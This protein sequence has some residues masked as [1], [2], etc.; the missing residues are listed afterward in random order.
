[1]KQMK[2]WQDPANALIGAWLVASPWVLGFQGNS[3]A[4]SSS[5]VIGVALIAAAAGAMWLPQ[6]WEEWTEAAL[7]VLMMASP[8]L[9][10]FTGL[11]AARTSA[12]LSGLAVLALALWVLGTDKD[13]GFL[14]E[15]R[16]AH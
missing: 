5:L 14:R 6:A 12:I 4:L 13:W 11:E 8:W 16:P 10:G 15:D 2:H 1:M 9:M 3:S 7:G